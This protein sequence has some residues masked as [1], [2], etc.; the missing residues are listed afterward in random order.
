MKILIHGAINGSNFGDCIFAHI[1]YESL[2]E[3]GT[4][5]FVKAPMFGLCD[6][7]SNEIIGYKSSINSIKN[8]DCLVYMSGGYFGDTTSSWKEAVKRYLRYF[9]IAEY[10][11]KNNK[12][13]YVCG[14]G[15]GPVSNKFLRNKIVK[16]LNAARF[17]SVRDQETADYFRQNG[18]QNRILITT[19]SALSIKDRK[20]PELSVELKTLTKDKKNIF[21]HVYGNDNSNKEISKKILP[22]LNRFLSVH[23]NKYR[24]FVGTDNICKTK[25]RDLE[26][27]KNLHG[28][29]VAVDYSSTWG[30]CSLL[31][32]MDAAIT[33]KLHVG[34]VTALYG[35]SV[36]SFPK[37]VNKTKRFYKQIGYSERCKLLKKV[38]QEDVYGMMSQFMD[39]KIS[40][41]LELIEK[42][43]INLQP[44][45]NV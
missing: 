13:I 22:S 36:I 17:V 28:D 5:D 39:E 15:G 31:K 27:F 44:F 19:D 18:V 14:V 21:F 4:V 40:I 2:A 25:I 37:H 35:K 30:L 7:L 33:V 12:P 9:R 20:I 45:K 32:Y 6:F 8:A 1:F 42:A 24:V 11:I 26:V 41:D 3:Q 34:I 29:K 10:F 43:C 23:S 16:I 38:E